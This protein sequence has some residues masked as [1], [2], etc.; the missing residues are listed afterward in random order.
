MHFRKMSKNDLLIL[1]DSWLLLLRSLIKFYPNVMGILLIG[2]RNLLSK[3]YSLLLAFGYFPLHFFL[4]TES[5]RN[6]VCISLLI[7]FY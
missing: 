5:T 4:S 3:A 7:F 6:C 2:S 1:R